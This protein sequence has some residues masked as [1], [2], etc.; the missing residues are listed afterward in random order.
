MIYSDPDKA[1]AQGA[2][3]ALWKAA[4]KLAEV[5]NVRPTRRG[6]TPTENFDRV[7]RDIKTQK[8]T[9]QEQIN[10]LAKAI[11]KAKA[12]LILRF[13]RYKK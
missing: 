9:A 10:L 6:L 1:H 3:E 13:P 7:L 8:R 2:S 5:A 11:E 4:R 12:S